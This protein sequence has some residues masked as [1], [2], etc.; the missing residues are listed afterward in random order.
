MGPRAHA[1]EYTGVRRVTVGSDETTIELHDGSTGA[2]PLRLT[3]MAVQELLEALAQALVQIR[4]AQPALERPLVVGTDTATNSTADQPTRQPTH[5][6]HCESRLSHHAVRPD[7]VLCE[8]GVL[9]RGGSPLPRTV[10]PRSDHG[11]DPSGWFFSHTR[12]C[13]VRESALRV[14]RIPKAAVS[15]A[16]C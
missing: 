10:R 4:E 6:V 9:A 14:L 1:L 5:R 7:C 3:P 11:Q 16:P 2:C 15:L 8:L 13:R 12:R